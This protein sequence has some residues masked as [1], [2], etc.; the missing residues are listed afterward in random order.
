MELDPALEAAARARK[1]KARYAASKRRTVRNQFTAGTRDGMDAT[2]KD[3]VRAELVAARLYSHVNGKIKLNSSQVASAK[4]LVD[5]GK[6][7]LQA[8]EQTVIES[9]ATR[10]EAD[11]LA[12]IRRLVETYPELV[13]SFLPPEGQVIDVTPVLEPETQCNTVIQ[14]LIPVLP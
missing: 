8:V 13:R 14:P 6:P 2:T 9:A 11:L 4:V 5:K 1:E 12:D 7:S 3:K 10:S